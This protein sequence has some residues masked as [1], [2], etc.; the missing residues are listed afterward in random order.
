MNKAST[1]ALAMGAGY[2]LGRKRKLRMALI[3]ASAAATG[4]VGDVAANALKRGG[5]LAASSGALDKLSPELTKVV[6]TMRG[7]L[8]DAGKAAVQAAVASRIESLTDSLHDR[9]EG[10]RNPA[11]PDEGEQDQPDDSDRRGG[12]ER[13]RSR[14][15][16]GSRPSARRDSERPRRGKP[17]DRGSERPRRREPEGNGEIKRPARRSSADGESRTSSSRRRGK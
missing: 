9:A 4:R 12:S 7:D 8:A 11:E 17:D 6:G 13:P 15:G 2:L 1:V 10:L 16:G 5:S 14:S 3:V